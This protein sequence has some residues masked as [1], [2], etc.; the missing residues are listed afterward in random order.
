M[1]L[2]LDYILA[3]YVELASGSVKCHLKKAPQIT[4]TATD[5]TV[6]YD[7]TKTQA[8]LDNFQVDTINPYGEEVQSHVGGLMS[9][10]VSIS[11]NMRFATESYP[12]INAGCLYIDRVNVELHINPTIF[13][14]RDYP[15]GGCMYNAV[16]EHEKKHIAVDREIVNK[17]S[18]LIINSLNTSLKQVGYAQGPFSLQQMPS[19]QEKMK[20]TVHGVIKLY[21][22]KMSEERRA[23]Q[24]K[25]DSI[26]EYDRVSNMCRPK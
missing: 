13:I 5:T 17:Y 15:K 19:V 2:G 10:E 8:Q 25:V 7:H 23:R 20:Q 22:A 12:M 21:S 18:T 1:V 26:Q 14:A 24:Q 4:I 3:S 16:M 9:G 6:K 11:E